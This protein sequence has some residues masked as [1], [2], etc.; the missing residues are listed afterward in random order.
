M[1][2]RDYHATRPC[3]TININPAAYSIGRNTTTMASRQARDRGNAHRVVVCNTRY[4]NR[5]TKM[6]VRIHKYQHEQPK[7]VLTMP[8]ESGIQV[9]AQT[10]IFLLHPCLLKKKKNTCWRGQRACDAGVGWGTS[11]L[12]YFCDIPDLTVVV[13]ENSGA[14]TSSTWKCFTTWPS[15]EEMVD[16]PH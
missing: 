16:G 6:R 14:V 8:E 7:T 1:S 5:H 12:C 10:Q 11:P 2:R 15:F 3:E 4:S 9:T 13:P